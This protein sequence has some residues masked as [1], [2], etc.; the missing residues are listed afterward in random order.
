MEKIR[1]LALS[2]SLREA[3]FNTSALTALSLLA[4]DSI[5]IS[6]FPL[7]DMPLFNPDKEDESSP[8]VKDLK[9]MLAS[10]D[11]LIIASPEYAHGVS[12]VIKNALDWL[13]SGH[14]FV[15]KPIMLIN[16]SP[17]ASHAQASLREILTTMSGKLIDSA[18]VSIPL[19]GAQLDIQGITKDSGIAG[20][21][22][23]GLGKFC[24][25]IRGEEESNTTTALIMIDMQKGMS[26]PQAGIRNNPHAEQDMVELLAYCR[27]QN[28]PLIHVR[29]HSIEPDSLFWPEQEGVEPQ[30]AFLPLEGEKVVVK[31]V[32]DA[33]AHSDLEVWLRNQSI[34]RLLVVG[35]STNN[36]VESTVRSAG[37][38]GFNTF[39]V[40]NACFAFEKEDFDG[41]HRSAQEVHAMSLANL[42]GE[43]ATVIQQEEALGLF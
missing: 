29:H 19:L 15:D 12:G 7:H 30:G 21:L 20:A 33:F 2:G 4:P 26:W 16:T 13:V 23:A 38:L 35:V 5:E 25:A 31:S 22:K 11:G 10:A 1:L 39:V 43:Y 32:P 34:D 14:E 24:Q 17:R 41:Q 3:S 28:Q 8:L 40:A 36:S 9:A 18:H 6:I 27:Q 37:N 42:D